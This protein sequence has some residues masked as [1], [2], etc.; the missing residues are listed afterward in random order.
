MMKVVGRPACR[1]LGHRVE[2]GIYIRSHIGAVCGLLSR[3]NHVFTRRLR[4]CHSH[5]VRRHEVSKGER[6]GLNRVV[7]ER[8]IINNNKIK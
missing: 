7:S 1:W 3:C 2:G 5:T 4:L 6:D 8:Y